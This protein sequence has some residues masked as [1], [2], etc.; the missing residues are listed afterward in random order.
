MTDID[1]TEM[2]AGTVKFYQRHII[3]CS[4]RT[5]WPAKI[6]L[7]GGYAQRLHEAV[8]KHAANMPLS[9]K[10]TACDEPSRGDEPDLL[11]FPDEVRYVGVREIDLDDF[12][13]DLL[14]QNVAPDWLRKENLDTHYIFV[15]AHGERDERCG[16]CAPVVLARLR[17]Q[18]RAWD[19]SHLVTVRSSS[20]VGGHAHACNVL[21]YP[22]GDW[23]GH[24][25]PD[26]APRL[27]EKHI[28]TNQT[29]LDLWRGRMGMTPEEQQVWAQAHQPGA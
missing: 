17:A 29:V 19:L 10:I 24:V 18:I 11:V 16:L 15:C 20:H 21:I 27:L 23:Y 22:P 5:G 9:V 13:D 28:L 1:S 14:V 4:G 26:D 3:I 8:A 12:V 2:L 6:D 25:T 7:D